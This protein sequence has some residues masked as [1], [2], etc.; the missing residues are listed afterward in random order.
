MRKISKEELDEILEKHKKWL[1]NEKGGERANL[2]CTKLQEVD[3]RGANLM[4]ADLYGADLKGAS[5][6]WADL[7]KA[8][9]RK[10]DLR[11][12]DLHDAKVQK[13]QRPWLL[14]A[15]DI[16]SR[17][18][19]TIYFADYDNIHCG[20]WNHGKGG[21]LA[22]FKK[23]IDEVY[24]AD[25]ENEEYQRYRLEYLSAIKMFED[26]REVYLKSAAQAERQR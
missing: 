26:M 10:A 25:S 15:G 21:T 23:R 1:S 2:S 17:N 6:R 13:V 9:L 22:E 8:D 24:P 12:V 16:G 5:L 7:R 3:L 14:Y 20:C 4:S 19:D 18:A 11:N